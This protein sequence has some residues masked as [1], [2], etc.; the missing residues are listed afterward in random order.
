MLQVCFPVKTA[1]NCPVTTSF[2]AIP[3]SNKGAK[4]SERSEESANKKTGHQGYHTAGFGHNVTDARAGRS[5]KCRHRLKRQLGPLRVALSG[6][7]AD[8]RAGAVIL[9][10]RNFESISL[11]DA[12]EGPEA[13]HG[14]FN[15]HRLKSDAEGLRWWASNMQLEESVS[16]LPSS[17]I[18][19][20]R[21]LHPHIEQ[22]PNNE[23]GH[24]LET[25]TTTET[26]V[27]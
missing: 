20:G 16:V 25:A 9:R 14:G 13:P 2:S 8:N 5:P 6:R 21:D 15:D 26:Q 7:Q 23:C 12:R 4:D 27:L 3:R 11:I 17:A 18:A 10:R 19:P 24:H 22:L 1:H